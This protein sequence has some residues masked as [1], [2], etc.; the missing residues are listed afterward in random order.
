MV[1]PLPTSARSDQ[2]LR[3][4]QPGSQGRLQRR[5]RSS[6]REISH[7]EAQKSQIQSPFVTFG[8]FV[9][10]FSPYGFTASGGPSGPDEPRKI[11][12]PSVKVRSL[13]FA[14]FVPSFAW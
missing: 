8:L 14:R 10:N 7:K 5:S 11:F 4:R 12:L 1:R 9:A 2:T 6:C 3:S 13:P